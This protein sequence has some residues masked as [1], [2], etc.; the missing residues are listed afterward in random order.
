MPS[1]NDYEQYIRLLKEL[2]YD[3]SE[4][5]LPEDS[6]GLEKLSTARDDESND[7]PRQHHA[8]KLEEQVIREK[9]LANDE[10]QQRI[11][12]QRRF[13][14]FALGII[15]FPVVIASIGFIYLV[16]KSG[17]SD[18]AYAAFFASVVAEVIGLSFILGNYFFPNRYQEKQVDPK[19]NFTET[20]N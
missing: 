6:P 15:G 9:T 14:Y 12:H 1:E 10:T 8:M 19:D 2:S 4:T 20:R 16:H 3:S 13:F 7:V 11:K 17:A 5:S 18:V